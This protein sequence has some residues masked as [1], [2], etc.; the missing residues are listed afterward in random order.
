MIR[1]TLT[2]S[3]LPT[4]N[5]SFHTFCAG[6]TAKM[7]IAEWS[8][9]HGLDSKYSPPTD[10]EQA[11]ADPALELLQELSESNFEHLFPWSLHEATVIADLAICNDSDVEYLRSTKDYAGF[12]EKILSSTDIPGFA[13][14]CMGIAG[15]RAFIQSN[16]T[17]P[18]L[19]FS[20]E[21][22]LLP[23]EL[24]EEP[25]FCKE[26]SKSIIASL[27]VDGET[28]YHLTPNVL[29]LAFGK[30]VLNSSVLKEN[31]KLETLP[32]WRARVNFLH[33]KVLSEATATL[34]NVIYE[35]IKKLVDLIPSQDSDLRAKFLVERALIDTYFGYDS[36][37]LKGLEEAASVTGLKYAITGVLGKRTK[38]Q[39]FDTSQLVVLA[40]SEE[41]SSSEVT[42]KP[43]T[44]DLN[45]DTILEAI[46][47]TPKS[48]QV[49]GESTLPSE[50]ASLDPGNQPQL[51]PLDAAILLLITETIKNTNPADGITRE[52]MLPYAERVLQHSVNWEIYT[53]GLLI[54]SRIE[55]YK[56]RTVERGLL[57]L[58]AVVDQVIADTTGTDIS[59]DSNNAVSTFL[60]KPKEDEVAPVKE[61]LLY[62][63]Q[64]S[65]PTRWE[66]EAELASRWISL[67]GI[68]TALE[69]YERLEMWAEVA[70]C[71][72]ATEKEDKA[73]KVIRDQLFHSVKSEDDSD[74]SR[75]EIEPVPPNAPRLWC[76]LGDIDQDPSHYERA[77]E[78]SKGRYARAKRSLG[79]H[80]FSKRE[81]QKSAEAYM[82]SL[83]QNPLNGPGWFALGCCWLELENWE[84]AV[85][86]FSRTVSLD[87]TDAEAWSNLATALLRRK[88]ELPAQSEWRNSDLDE[89]PE[90]EKTNYENGI[91]GQMVVD[92]E[93]NKRSAL[94]ALKKASSLKND[95]WRIWENLLLISATVSPPAYT[96]VVI[97]LRRIIEIRKDSAGET[98]LDVDVLEMLVRHIIT[99][100]LES[101]NPTGYDPK[102]P[103]LQKMVVELMDRDVVPLITKD[104]RL[105][106]IYAKLAL[107]RK[108]PKDALD[109]EEKA[110]RTVNSRPNIIDGTEKEWDELV[111]ATVD[112]VDA[113]QSLG[114][115]ERTEGLGAGELVAKDW[116]FKARTTVRGVMGQGRQNWEDTKGWGRLK[117]SLEGLK[118]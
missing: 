69:I 112:L 49:Q 22:V 66:L 23:D 51:Q 110:W 43:K 97:A 91:E 74:D 55:G 12:L 99:S 64:L 106:K 29:L 59:Y 109:A 5:S 39:T 62:I 103:G 82:E 48:T 105:W 47:F 116:R 90:D 92:K 34:H 13:L 58:Q 14:M 72:A 35:D 37:A 33:Q 85:E 79:R 16:I 86:A 53:L 61:R 114:E 65:V 1:G 50:L 104:G 44:L 45:D 17:G 70:L 27:S 15:V 40:R 68:R 32:W 77:W 26:L 95:S 30:I 28:A 8:L 36:R 89:N 81:Y 84:S 100:D 9:V 117:E 42:A 52:E 71:W 107:W 19:S 31:S 56:S 3:P 60:P 108:K 115:M 76:I 2:S 96:D 41:G 25:E 78:A 4:F 94:R 87:E 54:R 63:H 18:P 11:N 10:T 7:N 83:K 46:S 6:E 88:T 38:F 24:A 75:Q 118:A 101:N 93:N 20:P 57:Q 80:Y 98:A 73:R 67:G 21:R 102:K 113:Y 111:D